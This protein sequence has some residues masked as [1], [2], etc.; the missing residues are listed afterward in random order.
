MRGR[1]SSG[2][3]H[4]L[5]L[6]VAVVLGD[7]RLQQLARLVV[8]GQDDDF[9]L[10]CLWSHKSAEPSATI[11]GRV[12]IT[13]SQACKASQAA[14][15]GILTTMPLQKPVPRSNQSLFLSSYTLTRLRSLAGGATNAIVGT[16]AY[17]HS[18]QANTPSG[19][20][21]AIAMRCA[22]RR[23]GF[24]QGRA[25]G[26]REDRR[27]GGRRTP[28][29]RRCGRVVRRLLRG[30]GRCDGDETEWLRVV[31]AAGRVR[32]VVVGCGRG[33]V[34]VGEPGLGGAASGQNR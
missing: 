2:A 6:L 30:D 8:L 11:A 23:W 32:R 25:G 21:R 15:E 34:Q 12:A 31:I 27:L 3:R 10:F 33:C 9:R 18:R 28:A 7:A 4:T 16:R 5:L 13:I 19:V 29:T 1:V 24:A 22:G 14:G 17:T 26:W 20:K